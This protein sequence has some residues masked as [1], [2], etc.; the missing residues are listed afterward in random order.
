MIYLKTHGLSADRFSLILKGN[1]GQ[2]QAVWDMFKRAVAL[3]DAMVE[4]IRQKKIDHPS[5]LD[6]PN[7]GTCRFPLPCHLPPA[8]TATIRDMICGTSL[9]SFEGNLGEL[10]DTEVLVSQRE[11]WSTDDWRQEWKPLSSEVIKAPPGWTEAVF[12]M[13]CPIYGDS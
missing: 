6:E 12:D 13:Y 11:N 7:H 4:C 5:Q 2:T 10:W 8:F 9:I 3:Q 1:C